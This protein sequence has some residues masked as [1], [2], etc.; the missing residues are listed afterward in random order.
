[1]NRKNNLEYPIVEASPPRPYSH[2][3]KFS[4]FFV[5]DILNSNSI[6]GILESSNEGGFAT[7][8]RRVSERGHESRRSSQVVQS[9]QLDRDQELNP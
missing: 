8:G 9:L 2:E 3:S 6:Q 1:M 7:I 5:K 4:F